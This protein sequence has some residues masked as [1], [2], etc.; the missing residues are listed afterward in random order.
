MEKINGI[1]FSYLLVN[2]S[3]TRHNIELLFDTIDTIHNCIPNDRIKKININANYNEK[4]IKR[5][6]D[7]DYSKISEESEH[8]FKIITEKL[9]YFEMY[10]L[11]GVIHGDTVFSNIFLCDKQLIRFIDMRGKVG[12]V[13]T[14]F[15][16][17]FYDYAKIYQ[18]LIGYDFILNDYEI[19]ETYL[20][21]LREYFE[22]LFITKFSV[23]YLE[24]L[25][26]ITCGLLFSLIPLHNE[27]D[28]QK[29][30]FQLIKKIIK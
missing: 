29:K 8:Y 1:V 13:E 21:G 4:I 19:N 14:V 5:F 16:D 26:Y 15:G 22:H 7:F 27:L 2:N 3:L 25:K 28:K 30:Y 12:E 23:K 10:S 9:V 11:I 6:N 24:Y 17:V 20:T 18:S